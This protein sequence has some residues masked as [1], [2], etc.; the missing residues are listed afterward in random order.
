M[1]N[2]SKHISK[3]YN[4][5]YWYNKKTKVSV[6]DKPQ[7][8]VDYELKKE[9]ERKT[10]KE[11]DIEYMRIFNQQKDER[12]KE[13]NGRL[14]PDKETYGMKIASGNGMSWTIEGNSHWTHE[15][16]LEEL[17]NINQSMRDF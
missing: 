8:V 17:R 3:S 14:E 1:H 2:W 7:E 11:K 13:K 12:E 6:W 10:R 4:R 16:Y 15:D 5:E 9:H